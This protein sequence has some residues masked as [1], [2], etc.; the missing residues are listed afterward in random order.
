MKT[1]TK[2]IVAFATSLS[3]LVTATI[4]PTNVT[5][6]ESTGKYNYAE[7]LQKSLFFYEVQQSGELPEWNEVEWRGD[8]TTHDYITGGWFDAG[9]H[10][11]FNLPMSYSATMMAWGLYLYGDGVEEAGLGEM[12]RNNLDFVLDYLARCDLG[13]E[14]VYQIGDGGADHKWWGSAELIELEMERPYYTCKASCVTGSMAA[15]LAA[16]ALALGE[17]NEKHDY[18]I[19]HAKNLFE[20]ADTYRSDDDYTQAN[21]YYDSWS[22]FYDQLFWAANWLYMATGEQEYLDKA[23]SYIPNLNKMN[24]STELSYTWGQC[25]DD[26]M[27]GGMLLYAMNTGDSTYIQRVNKHLDTW[28]NGTDDKKMTDGGLAW[29]SQWGSLRYATT[30]GFLAS[31][32]SDYIAETDPTNSAKYE[33]FA[34]KQINYC[35]GDNPNNFSYVIGFGENYPQ[36]PHHRTAQGAWEDLQGALGTFR[37]TLYGALVGGPTSADDNAYEDSVDNYQANEVAT[38]YNAGFTALLCKMV[39]KY[40]GEKLENFPQSEKAN[41]EFEELFVQA[42][43]NQDN[44]NFTELKVLATNH[45][46]WPARYTEDI[47]Y[48]YYFDLSELEGTDYTVDDITISKGYDEWQNTEISNPIHYK[49]NIYY[50]EIQYGEGSVI[51]PIG[52]EQES[53]ELQFRIAMPD[54]SNVWDASNDYSYQGLTNDTQNLYV[55][56]YITMYYDGVLV[57]GVEPDGTTPD[58]VTPTV[59]TTTTETTTSQTTPSDTELDV[60]YI[61][62]ITNITDDTI[63]INVDGD[64]ITLNNAMNKDLSSFE[65]GSEV[66]VTGLDYGSSIVLNTIELVG[67]VTTETTT[68]TSETPTET[69]SNTNSGD[70]GGTLLGDANEDGKVNSADLL[71]IR[72]HLLH[73]EDLS[74]IGKLNADVNRDGQVRSNDITKIKRVLIHLDDGFED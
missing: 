66:K 60:E 64:I 33:E 16:G 27:Q 61:G 62:T 37:H 49:D 45:T 46:A 18:Y 38:D 55:T 52:K 65:V 41:D 29:M 43:L 20:I 70:F 71:E 14:V 59:T 2:K 50:V 72:K 17:D 21:G 10:V 44:A 23:T 68:D 9:D 1:F 13:D 8:S 56:P 48:R 53:A 22:G 69:T 63:E 36:N 40:G 24:Q 4:M 32:W 57:W 25:W 58:D 51:A 28:A 31:V 67:D 7:V 12:Y 11:K 42:C 5:A 34:E 35:L 47:S 73:I 26:V 74:E 19:E 39:S 30:A 54:A 6:Q 3:M 15:A